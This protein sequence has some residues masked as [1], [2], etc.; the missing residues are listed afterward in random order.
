MADTRDLEAQALELP[1]RERARLAER[2]ISSLDPESEPEAEGVWLH[3]AERRLAE[4]ESRAVS[5]VQADEVIEKARST[6]R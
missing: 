4:V 5:A 6:L 3:E 1:P 2:L